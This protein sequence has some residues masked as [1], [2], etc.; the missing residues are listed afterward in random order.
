VQ[1]LTLR[2]QTECELDAETS[3]YYYRARYY[4]PDAGRFFNED[5]LEGGGDGPNFYRYVRNDPANLRDPLGLIPLAPTFPGL[6]PWKP[7]SIPIPWGGVLGAAGRAVTIGLAV[8]YDL[9]VGAKPFGIDDAR[10]IPKP[11]PCMDKD[12]VQC[13]LSGQ[14]KDPSVD[15]K[16]KMC[17]YSCSDGTARV[18]VIHIGLPCPPTPDRLPQ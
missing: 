18:Y 17:S 14:F 11:P 10:A 3:L 7:I 16:F 8:V 9:T 15:P 12:K 6:W 5:P 13:W 4:D 1:S 2:K